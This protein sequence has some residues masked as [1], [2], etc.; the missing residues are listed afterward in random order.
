MLLNKISRSSKQQFLIGLMF[1][2]SSVLNLTS[3]RS[4]VLLKRGSI[5]FFL[6][7]NEVGKGAN[8]IWQ[9][10]EI[11]LVT[12]LKQSNNS[13]D[14]VMV[15]LGGAPILKYEIIHSPNLIKLIDDQTQQYALLSAEDSDIEYWSRLGHGNTKGL[16]CGRVERL[17]LTKSLASMTESFPAPLIANTR[18]ITAME[19]SLASLT[20]DQIKS[21]VETLEDLGTRFHKSSNG[22]QI[23]V[24]I[25]NLIASVTSNLEIT[26][27][28]LTHSGSNQKS[29]VAKLPGADSS[30]G[31]IVMGAHSDSINSSS[32][33][34][35]GA[36]PGADDDASGVATLIEILRVIND[37]QLK[38]RRDVEFHFYAA[39]E[40]GLVGSSDIAGDYVNAQKPVIAML[41]LDMN[42]YS[43]DASKETIYFPINDTDPLLRRGLK[44]LLNSYLGGDYIEK[45]LSGGTSDHRSW[46]SRN[47]PA[48]FP[49]EDPESYNPYIHSANDTTA[50]AN[51]WPLALRFAK[52][53]LLFTAHY[54]GLLSASSPQDLAES[55]AVG[56]MQNDIFLAAL[57][58]S[59]P[60][61]IELYSSADA[62]VT[63]LT[64]CL[65][66]V[67]LSE[68]CHSSPYDFE[69]VSVTE[70]R[71]FFKI[72]FPFDISDDLYIRLTGYNSQ[73]VAV[74]ERVTKVVSK[75]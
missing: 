17:D 27:A 40:V 52:L 13:N 16:G 69:L 23:D 31:I 54:G 53:G 10:Q 4:D 47:V 59:S 2:F 30:A 56:T 57:E 18:Q 25:T 64:L 66:S 5:S 65:G 55:T 46:S 68:S 61:E 45:Y 36:A 19:S 6:E 34:N 42:S 70:G 73:N 35:E 22:E 49:F 29:V 50:N 39:E 9:G 14:L 44:D 72:D 63:T 67:T 51:N 48:V 37:G 7:R 26:I 60:S 1:I 71:S 32:D 3:C 43:S 15:S 20:A 38:F 24:T 62:N 12:N 74:S 21:T 33:Q 8:V 58:S 28:S 75:Q 11:R 41:Q